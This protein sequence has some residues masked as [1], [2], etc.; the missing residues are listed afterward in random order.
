MTP[1]NPKILN[2]ELWVKKYGDNLYAWAYH[3]TGKKVVA[4]DLVQ[5]TF[6]SALNAMDNFTGSSSEK[7]WLFAILKNK[8][9][10]HF[11]KAFVKYEKSESELQHASQEGSFLSRFFD[12]YGSWNKKDRP[13]NWNDDNNNLLDDNEFRRILKYC[14][15]L[16]PDKWL[17]IITL[18]FLLEKNT[19]EVCK[20]LDITPSNLWVVIHRSKLQ[21]RACIEKNFLD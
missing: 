7:T 12:R 13:A 10:D 16:L 11:K 14:M 19:T 20:D 4:E 6:L 8:I 17:S 15:D 9:V 5:E 1:S 21:L 2:P 18:R 3:R